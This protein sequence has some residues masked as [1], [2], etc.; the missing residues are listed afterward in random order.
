MTGSNSRSLSGISSALAVAVLCAGTAMPALAQGKVEARISTTPGPGS[1]NVAEMDLFA[2]L[3][4]LYSRGSIE[5]KVFHSSVLGKER[6]QLEGLV[7]GSHDVFVHIS[8]ITGKFPA[9]RLWDLPFLFENT[10][11]V[12]RLINSD[13]AKDWEAAMAKENIVYLGTWGFGYRQFTVRNKP[14]NSP[15]DLVGQKHRIPGGKSKQ[16][17]FEALGAS[18]S[19]IAF[20]ELYQALNTGVVDSQ[21][22]PMDLIYV[23]KFHEVTNYISLLN[24]VYNPLITIA[25]RPFWDKLTAAQQAAMRRAAQDVEGWSINEANM[26]D[27]FALENKLKER[28]DYKVNRLDPATLPQ[29]REKAKAVYSAFAEETSQR[30]LDAIRKTVEKGGYYD[31]GTLN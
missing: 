25:G 5:G 6:A 20:S 15:A 10:D 11:Q 19:T 27:A 22:N 1:I 14:Y 13:I 3:A 9:V 16:L 26:R 31:V 2:N 30:Y 28:P 8:A 12:M 24:Y 29:W 4:E 21:D 7:T 17:L 18:P 23:T